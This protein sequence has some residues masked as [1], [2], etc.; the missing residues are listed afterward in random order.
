MSKIIEAW[1]KP[2]LMR[3]A[4]DEV[5]MAVTG[6]IAV[7]LVLVTIAYVQVTLEE[8]RNANRR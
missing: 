2:H 6:T 8:R 4:W 7:L 3:T 5:I 1:T